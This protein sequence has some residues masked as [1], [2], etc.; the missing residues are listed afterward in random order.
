MS[1]NLLSWTLLFDLVFHCLGGIVET[2]VLFQSK[3]EP[4]NWL[5]LIILPLLVGASFREKKKNGNSMLLVLVC[6]NAQ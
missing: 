6:I 4:V 5:L 3:R 1:G 2:L